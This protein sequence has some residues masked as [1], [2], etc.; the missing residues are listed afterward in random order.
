[1]L[2]KEQKVPQ[3]RPRRKVERRGSGR[4]WCGLNDLGECVSLWPPRITRLRPLNLHEK[5]VPSDKEE[6]KLDSK[7]V[8]EIQGKMTG[9]NQNLGNE[10]CGFSQ[11]CLFHMAK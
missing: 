1:M 5:L 7:K 3:D 2:I 11:K 10:H 9:S 4:R 6:G 8:L